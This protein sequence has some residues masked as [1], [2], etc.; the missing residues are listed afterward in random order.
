MRSKTEASAQLRTKNELADSAAKNA[1]P[2]S[3]S[4]RPSKHLEASSIPDPPLP[5]MLFHSSCITSRNPFPSVHVLTATDSRRSSSLLRS[6]ISLR[7][8][9]LHTPLHPLLLNL[10]ALPP[11]LPPPPQPPPALD[12]ALLITTNLLPA[13]GSLSQK[14]MA[15]AAWISPTFSF[16][17]TS[18][19]ATGHLKTQKGRNSTCHHR[20]E[21]AAIRL[22]WFNLKTD[23]RW[24]RKILVRSVVLQ[25]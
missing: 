11:D 5:Y 23:T 24:V 13:T 15:R 4:L 8:L 22:S 25:Q 21:P 6:G 9:R 1:M 14:E 18:Q 2:S 3:S 7:P 12:D 17:K 19:K 16:T 10:P 20:E